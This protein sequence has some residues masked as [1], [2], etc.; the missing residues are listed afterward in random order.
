MDEF[1]KMEM[2]KTRP[3][4][5]TTWYQWYDCLINHISESKGETKQKTIR[6]FQ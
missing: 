1:E 6:L 4:T 5:K 3:I 2:A